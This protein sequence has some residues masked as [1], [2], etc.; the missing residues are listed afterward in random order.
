MQKSAIGGEEVEGPTAGSTL[1]FSE[2]VFYRLGQENCA[3]DRRAP[4]G[5]CAFVF[6]HSLVRHLRRV[7]MAYIA[8]VSNVKG[9]KQF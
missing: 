5:D 2:Q 8:Y 4:I 1:C 6:T 7:L 3:Q 9:R